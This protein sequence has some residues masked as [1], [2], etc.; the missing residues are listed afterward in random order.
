MSKEL[1]IVIR[2]GVKFVALDLHSGGY[3]HMVDSPWKAEHWATIEEAEDYRITFSDRAWS[4]EEYRATF[5]RVV[6]RFDATKP[7]E[8]LQ[9]QPVAPTVSGNET[10]S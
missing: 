1:A 6:T 9:S 10:K 2:E 3:P 8:I 5:V 7:V 4:V